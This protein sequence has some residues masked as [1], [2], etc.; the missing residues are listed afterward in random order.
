M[1][2]Q[3]KSTRVTFD[4]PPELAPPDRDPPPFGEDAPIRE[5]YAR[6]LRAED[7]AL[8]ESLCASVL[9]LTCE[10]TIFAQRIEHG[11]VCDEVGAVAAELRYAADFL[12]YIGGREGD[13]LSRSEHKLADSAERIAAQVAALAGELEAAIAAVEHE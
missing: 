6:R 7:R 12:A 2:D 11:G 4:L 8:L 13:A 10:A 1:S 9:E 5:T 3:P